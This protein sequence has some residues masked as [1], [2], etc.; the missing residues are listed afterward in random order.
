MP[1]GLIFSALAHLVPVNFLGANYGPGYWAAF[2]LFT[3]LLN[4]AVFD[5]GVFPAIPPLPDLLRIVNGDPV[6]TLTIGIRGADPSIEGQR[7]LMYPS[8]AGVDFSIGTTTDIDADG[9]IT[10]LDGNE[11]YDTPGL[12]IDTG[13]DADADGGGAS[14]PL[15]VA[16]RLVGTTGD[17]GSG[18]GG[19]FSTKASGINLGLSNSLTRFFNLTDTK[20]V[21]LDGLYFPGKFAQ[22]ASEETL[23]FANKIKSTVGTRQSFFNDQFVAPRPK[24]YF[25]HRKF[26]NPADFISPGRDG[27]S[28]PTAFT[29]NVVIASEAPV[30]AIFVSGSDNP[31]FLF[32]TYKRLDIN[33]QTGFPIGTAISHNLSQTSQL[34]SSF[35]DG[36]G[37]TLGRRGTGAP[38][39]FAISSG[40]GKF[41]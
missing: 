30:K 16:S 38:E 25:S 28:F 19:L 27:R 40:S 6:T 4:P 34:T 23:T 9:T 39:D 13:D 33:S 18:A 5:A 32:R 41:T 36:A 14:T 10:I 37:G 15:T 7:I 1:G 8:P 17:S 11:L 29:E 12:G 3:A 22:L 35:K 26:G 2:N 31:G 20:R 21:F 24:F